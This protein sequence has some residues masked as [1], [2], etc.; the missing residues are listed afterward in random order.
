MKQNARLR[1]AISLIM[2]A[3]MGYLSWIMINIDQMGVIDLWPFT[4]AKYKFANYSDKGRQLYWIIVVMDMIY[5]TNLATALKKWLP[6]W[7][8]ILCLLL[9][10]YCE[11]II[12]MMS[13]YQ[14]ELVTSNWQISVITSIKWIF[15][16]YIMYKLFK[17]K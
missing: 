16:F 1:V 14:H 10:D 7:I 9:F 13:L 12:V 8:P 5:I 15:V 17:R 3:I 2:L 4:D 11:N 6:S